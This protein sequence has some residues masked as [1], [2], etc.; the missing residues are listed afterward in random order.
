MVTLRHTCEFSMYLGWSDAGPGTFISSTPRGPLNKSVLVYFLQQQPCF[1]ERAFLTCTTTVDAPGGCRYVGKVRKPGRAVGGVWAD[2]GLARQE[3]LLLMWA[4]GGGFRIG[5]FIE[6]R[7]PYPGKLY[8][9]QPMSIRVYVDPCCALFGWVYL[10][11][12]GGTAMGVCPLFCQQDPSTRV[13]LL[14]VWPH[15]LENSGVP[16][17]GA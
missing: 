13:C 9:N 10:F 6:V 16:L 2:L 5:L 14:G 11:V 8:R 4:E 12:S 3:T 15:G 1:R 17:K 7:S